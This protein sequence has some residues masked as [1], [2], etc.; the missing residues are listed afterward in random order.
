[1]YSSEK[2]PTLRGPVDNQGRGFGSHHLMTI[3]SQAEVSRPLTALGILPSGP[4][5][6]FILQNDH[7]MM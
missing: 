4:F 2:N 6:L 5:Q 1:M 3:K 7:R